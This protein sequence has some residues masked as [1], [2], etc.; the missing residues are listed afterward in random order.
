MLPPKDGEGKQ[1]PDPGEP[2]TSPGSAAATRRSATAQLIDIRG[3]VTSSP[4]VPARRDSRC[5]NTHNLP[6][7]ARLA[8]EF[9]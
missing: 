4:Q 7:Q 3:C 8:A 5:R 2:S 6:A 9:H 1:I